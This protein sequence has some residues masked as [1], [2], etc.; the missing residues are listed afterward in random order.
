MVTDRVPGCGPVPRHRVIRRHQTTATIADVAYW[1]IVLQNAGTSRTSCAVRLRSG[2]CRNAE[3]GWR[4]LLN[5]DF[6]S[7]RPSLA[8]GVSAL[9]KMYPEMRVNSVF[10]S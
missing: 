2:S 8:D 10:Q 7:T 5:L 9:Y 6:M 4:A 3:L 1:Q